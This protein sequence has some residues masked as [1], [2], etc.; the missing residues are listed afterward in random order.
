MSSDETEGASATPEGTDG[1]RPPESDRAA[2][3]EQP[4]SEGRATHAPARLFT[5][6]R[7]WVLAALV[8]LFFFA[9]VSGRI[10]VPA[11]F[12]ALALSAVSRGTDEVPVRALALS[13]GFSL[14]ASE[15]AELLAVGRR[16]LR[17]VGLPAMLLAVFALSLSRNL[18]TAVARA[19]LVL[20]VLGYVL[21]ICVLVVVLVRVARV[22]GSR[23]PRSA[24]LALVILPDM[25]R[26]L[27]PS[28]PSVPALTGFLATE[29]MRI[30]AHLR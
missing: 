11:L 29:L 25:L 2:S 7:R 13:R 3:D 10:V 17:V 23:R 21:L 12:S 27:F 14:R 6:A 5:S 16:M 20:G 22:R 30:G 28:V 4:P 1:T 18:H 9:L 26:G 19:L 15:R 24:L 8:L